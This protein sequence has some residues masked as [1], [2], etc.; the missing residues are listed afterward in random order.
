MSIYPR[1][2]RIYT[3]CCSAHLQYPYICVH[4]PLLHIDGQWR[5]WSSKFGDALGERKQLN[6]EMQLDTVIQ[7]VWSLFSWRQRSSEL[8]NEIG[9]C[10]PA[11]LDMH[12]DTVI[13]WV[14]TYNWRSDY[15]RL[16]WRR[17]IR[18]DVLHELRPYSF[19]NMYLGEWRDFSITTSTDGSETGWELRSVVIRMM[20][21]LRIYCARCEL[22]IMAW[23]DTEW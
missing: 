10:D 8:S 4:L 13:E 15:R 6:S 9:D 11:N 23:R 21:V 16:T 14:W 12:L 5:P 7:L 3:H 18:R 20:Q 1:V 17:Y 19:V 2:S 22:M